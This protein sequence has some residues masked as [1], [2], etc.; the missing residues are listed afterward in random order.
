M[1][2]EGKIKSNI[3]I[4]KYFTNNVPL[5]SHLVQHFLPIPSLAEEQ[6]EQKRREML[7][8]QS[9]KSVSVGTGVSRL[10]FFFPGLGSKKQ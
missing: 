5:L 10:L 2:T 7:V 1:Q 6:V 4:F 9:R 8:Y 3:C